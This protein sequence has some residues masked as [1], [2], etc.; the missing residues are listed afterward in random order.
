MSCFWISLLSS[1]TI[2]DIKKIDKSIKKKPNAKEFCILLKKN[3]KIC[4]NVKI[5]EKDLTNQ[6][7][8]EIF[9]WIKDYDCTTYNSGTL[10]GTSDPF[11]ILLCELL[12][13]KII[14]NYKGNL[15]KYKF[16]TTINYINIKK[17]IK[18]LKYG[19]NTGHFYKI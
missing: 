9:N 5:N 19:S 12:E 6:F 2:D 14:H 17:I 18:T 7:L 13:V 3:N 15:G 16:N 11:L 10:V 8:K 1:L 4:K